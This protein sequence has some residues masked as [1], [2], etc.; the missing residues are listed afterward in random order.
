MALTNEGPRNDN[1][2][3][4]KLNKHSEPLSAN[5]NPRGVTELD[6]GRTSGTTTSRANSVIMQ[7]LRR[8]RSSQ[9]WWLGCIATGSISRN[10]SED[11]EHL[12]CN[13]ISDLAGPTAAVSGGAWC[14]SLCE[15]GTRAVGPARWDPSPMLRACSVCLEAGK[16]AISSG[17]EPAKALIRWLPLPRPSSY[18]L[19][20][21]TRP[22]MRPGACCPP[23]P[24]TTPDVLA[25]CESPCPVAL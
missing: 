13:H 19:H 9:V 17:F 8:T 7:A 18:S 23:V 5:R 22:M 16:E 3:C 10:I 14:F 4:D 6:V 11:T 2:A 24:T 1:H 20:W 15:G 21:M 25:D 12:K